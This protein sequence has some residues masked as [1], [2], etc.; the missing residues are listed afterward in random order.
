M[1]IRKELLLDKE[2][3]DWLKEKSAEEHIT[4]SCLIRQ[5]LWFQKLSEEKK[6]KS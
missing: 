1:K 5:Y 4:M 6:K 3:F 2:L